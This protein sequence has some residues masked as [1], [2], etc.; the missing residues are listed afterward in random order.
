MP[1][2]HSNTPLVSPAPPPPPD[3]LQAQA[4][5]SRKKQKRTLAWEPEDLA[6]PLAIHMTLGRSITLGDLSFFTS[7]TGIGIPATSEWDRCG[8]VQEG[9]I[10]KPS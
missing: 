5:G 7:K 4:P 8:Q 1:P 10:E 3:P 6:L 2:E 9:A